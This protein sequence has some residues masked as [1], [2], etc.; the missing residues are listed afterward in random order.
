M[1]RYLSDEEEHPDRVVLIRSS[2]MS[3]LECAPGPEVVHEAFRCPLLE[4]RQC[5]SVQRTLGSRMRISCELY[6]QIHKSESSQGFLVSDPDE[7]SMIPEIILWQPNLG[8]DPD[9]WRPVTVDK[10]FSRVLRPH[11]IEGIKFLYGCLMGLSGPPGTEG[12]ILADDMGLGKTLQSITVMWTLLNTNVRGISAPAV[13][14]TMVLCPASLVKNWSSEIQKW[15][16]NK[17]DHVTVAESTRDRIIGQFTNFRYSQ[18]SKV[19]VCSYEAFRLHG[20]I[21][22][23][24]HIDLLICDE[25]HRLKND[26]TKLSVCISKIEAKKRLLLT[27]TPIQNDISEFFS[28]ISLALPG[29]CMEDFNK[30]F[31]LP[32]HKAREPGATDK[33]IT[34]GQTALSELSELSNRFIL[35]RTNTLLSKHLPKKHLL[36]LFCDLTPTQRKIYTSVAD[37][38]LNGK[39]DLSNRALR[40]TQLMMKICCHPS[41]LDR[42]GEPF[43]NSEPLPGS[44]KD[45]FAISSKLMV[46]RMLLM[47]FRIEQDKCVVIST[48]TSCLEIVKQLCQ[49][50]GIRSV[51]LDGSVNISRRHQLVTLFNEQS[52]DGTPAVFLLSSKAG[53]CGINLIGANRL[54]M[55]D[56]DWNP[57]TD[58]QAMARVWREGQKKVC[59]I[60]RLFST[61]SIEEKILQRQINK[62]GLSSS[63]VATTGQIEV[64]QGLA[65]SEMKKLFC[66]KPVGIA[67]DTHEVLQCKECS[68]F[69]SRP[70]EEYIEEDLNTWDHL[71]PDQVRYSDLLLHEGCLEGSTNYVTMF[72]YSSIENSPCSS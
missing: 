48:Y 55:L 3:I 35:R 49:S 30:R 52:G 68:G 17:C 45:N 39:N 53:G 1:K 23:D 32:I 24:C 43:I 37:W 15:T 46:L 41:L 27:G 26:K 44:E 28:M 33:Q 34:A 11:Q 71:C 50:L 51:G 56:A 16:R 63:L 20:K 29:L 18:S 2:F 31:A 9:S 7:E 22:K 58:K 42:S 25:A 72:M 13:R 10:M 65:R 64:K 66:L 12:C 60:Y 67:S 8:R 59:W 36:I 57:A 54:V 62:N 5:E 47:N 61:G 6:E 14:R 70:V 21:V 38:L 4:D 40:A 69:Q 19:L